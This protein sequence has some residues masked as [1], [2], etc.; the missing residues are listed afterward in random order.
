MTVDY[1][2]VFTLDEKALECPYEQFRR[3]RS[4]CPV[5]FGENIGFWVVSDHEHVMEVLREARTFSTKEMLGPQAAAQ[6]QQM[7]DMAAATEE[8][9]ERLGADYGNSPRKTLL[10]ADPPEHTQHRR[11]ITRALSAGAVASWEPRVRET[12][13][14]FVDGLETKPE[15]EFVADFATRYT[16]T[17]IADILGLPREM[18]QQ[19]LAWTHGFNSMVGNPNLTEEELNGLRDVRLGFDVYFDEQMTL[20]KAEPTEDL[21]SRVVTLNEDS[22]EPLSRDELF[23][24]LQ[25]L[26]VG[27]SDTSSTALST[28][29][30]FLAENPQEWTRLRENP[31]AIPQFI[32]ELMRAESPVQGMFRVVTKDVELGGQQ[33]K[34]GDMLWL[35]LGSA[36]RDPKVFTDPDVVDLDRK[37]PTPDFVGFG[38]GPHLCPGAA[39]TRMELRVAL[40]ELTQRFTGV[41]MTADRSGRLPSFL[42][43]GPANLPV[44][45][46]TA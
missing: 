10:F 4:E 22:D 5:S 19:L 9:R 35:S 45:F 23:M 41:Q 27:G 38:G 20:R 28:M 11:L 44:R 6:W 31:T 17:V 2:S 3:A 30:E 40:E 18:V 37:A 34:K 13:Q 15:Q 14:L 43:F 39:L 26:V 33:L 1:E 12:A 8:G 16:M 32:E 24:V 21:V 7:I 46:E 25:L 42:F 29:V 36:N